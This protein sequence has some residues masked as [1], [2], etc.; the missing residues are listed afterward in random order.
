[1]DNGWGWNRV[2]QEVFWIPLTYKRFGQAFATAGG[3]QQGDNATPLFLSLHLPVVDLWEIVASY[4]R[5]PFALHAFSKARGYVLYEDSGPLRTVRTRLCLDESLLWTL[6]DTPG[7]F[8]TT[9][10]SCCL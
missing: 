3:G 1:V 6:L 4:L 7:F 9:G 5:F 8:K 2:P 10:L